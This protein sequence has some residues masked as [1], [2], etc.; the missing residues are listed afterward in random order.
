MIMRITVRRGTSLTWKTEAI[1]D[2]LALALN[3]PQ[4]ELRET[5]FHI[6]SG[7]PPPVQPQFF[8][9]SALELFH[10]EWLAARDCLPIDMPLRFPV[11]VT[12]HT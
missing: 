10:D 6:H 1:T 8:A 3:N 9:D 2:A 5:L 12:P 11:H 4:S 7:Q